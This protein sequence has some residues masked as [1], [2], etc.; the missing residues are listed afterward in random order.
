[1]SLRNMIRGLNL[2]EKLKENLSY[3]TTPEEYVKYLEKNNID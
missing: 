2:K 1:M 3:E